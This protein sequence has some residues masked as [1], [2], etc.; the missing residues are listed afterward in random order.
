MFAFGIGKLTFVTFPTR[1]MVE[2][3]FPQ[4]LQVSLSFSA[5]WEE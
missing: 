3:N 2:G 5:E 4:N 1:N